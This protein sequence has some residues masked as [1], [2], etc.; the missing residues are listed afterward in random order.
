MQRLEGRVAVVT[1]GA[2]GIG[3]VFAGALAAQGAAV[4]IADI[5]DGGAA[6]ESIVRD[7]PA[8]RLADLP[9]DIS[10]EAACRRLVG[11]T[12]DAFGRLD[13]LVNNAKGKVENGP[14]EDLSPD[15]W[16][17][18][19]AVAVR[20]TFLCT[21]AAVPVM[22]ARRY[23][24]IINLASATAFKGQAGMLH[25]VSAKGAL[26]AMTRALARELGDDGIR[27]NA[28][29][30]GLTLSETILAEAGTYGDRFRDAVIGSRALKRDELPG[31]LAGALVFL[32]GPDSDFVTGQCLVVDGG[33]LT[34]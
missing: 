7:H 14:L 12:V 22:R 18:M 6:I 27:V 28:L 31:D 21:K 25:Y 34:R 9:T 30:P 32:A 15:D 5:L 11:R 8:A 29:A 17:R 26:I 2:Q 4:V 3:A 20:G 23:G 33:S 1:G 16:D 13:V 24:K 10:D 19:F